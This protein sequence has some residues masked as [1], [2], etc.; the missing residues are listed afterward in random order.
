MAEQIVRQFSDHHPR[1]PGRI[2]TRERIDVCL[3]IFRIYVD[4]QAWR[5]RRVHSS[6]R[7]ECTLEEAFAAL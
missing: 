6:Y 1:H 4:Q 2:V 3:D 5:E 7:L